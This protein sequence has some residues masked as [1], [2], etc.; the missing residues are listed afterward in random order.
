MNPNDDKRHKILKYFYDRNSTATS[1]FGKKGSSVKISDVKKELKDKY[2]LSQQEVIS[3]LNYLIDQNWIKVI[4]DEKQIPVRGGITIPSKVTWYEISADGIDKIEGE[5]E[6]QSTSRFA[7]I[8]INATGENIITLGD[9]NIV[10]ANYQTLHNELSKLK[11]LL[12]SS[13]RMSEE[14]KLDVIAD[15]ET[16][17][18][19]LAKKNPNKSIIS[20]L[21]SGIEKISTTAGIVDL[22]T[23]ISPLIAGLT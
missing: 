19:Q 22:I 8:N 18:D 15:I 7:G 5:S 6:F 2:E 4:E 12:T 13:D 1:K 20:Q 3:N 21:W 9:G 11:E 23:K 14:N 10:N 16:I 17:K